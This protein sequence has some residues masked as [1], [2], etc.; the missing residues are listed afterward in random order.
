[1]TNELTT[2]ALLALV[3]D[4]AELGAAHERVRV[5]IEA[6]ARAHRVDIPKAA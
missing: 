4:L 2:R 1:M 6:L 3:S 5:Q